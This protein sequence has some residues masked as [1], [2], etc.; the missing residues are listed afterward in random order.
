[1]S[2]EV[3]VT[4]L[5]SEQLYGPPAEM[6]YSPVACDLVCPVCGAR[7]VVLDDEHRL[8][9]ELVQAEPV[10]L[11]LWVLDVEGAPT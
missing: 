10:V 2:A 5:H 1:M 4:C 7:S 6:V 9:V 8:R 11:D 3:K